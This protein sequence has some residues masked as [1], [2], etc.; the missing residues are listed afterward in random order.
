M[1]RNRFRNLPPIDI[2]IRIQASY[3]SALGFTKL[4]TSILVEVL[5]RYI[6]LP[7]R[8]PLGIRATADIDILP[9]AQPDPF[10][11]P[12]PSLEVSN[13]RSSPDI[14]VGQTDPDQLEREHPPTP[15]SASKQRFGSW[16]YSPYPPTR[17]SRHGYSR[18]PTTRE[19]KP[20]CRRQTDWLQ[21]T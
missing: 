21:Y 7:S 6:L 3:P 5:G 16:F 15:R 14:S 11:C 8:S 4:Q 19:V 1:R 17:L 9:A 2:L 10:L 20:R 12:C 13:P 18:S